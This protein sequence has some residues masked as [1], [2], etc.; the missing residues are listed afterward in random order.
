MEDV[1]HKMWNA[2]RLQNGMK[3]LLSLLHAKKP[4]L[5][6]DEIRCL[7]CKVNGVFEFRLKKLLRHFM[8]YKSNQ[9]ISL[10]GRNVQ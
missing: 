7:A 1:V 9:S 5:M 4:V 6:A 10:F 3:V 2:V 8:N